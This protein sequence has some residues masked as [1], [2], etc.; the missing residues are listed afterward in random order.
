M[1]GMVWYCTMSCWPCGAGY[2]GLGADGMATKSC[3]TLAVNS[4]PLSISLASALRPMT[5]RD[6]DDDEL[7]V[8]PA[9]SG[10]DRSL[11]AS[12]LVLALALALAPGV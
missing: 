9:Q 1:S 5:R 4:P 3:M 7:M 8:W 12:S 10:S 11:L 2:Y 6:G